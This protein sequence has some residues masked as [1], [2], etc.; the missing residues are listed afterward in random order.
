MVQLT[1]TKLLA[2]KRMSAY[3]LAKLAGLTF[4][5]V[6]RM[7]RPGG[8]FGRIEAKTLDAICRVLE[9]QPGDLLERVPDKP[10]QRGQ[11]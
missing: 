9:C 7:T 1:L 3:R 5:T 6:Y 10:S 4:G 8:R 2:R 11:P